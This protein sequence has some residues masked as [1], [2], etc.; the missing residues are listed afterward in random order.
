MLTQAS[1]SMSPTEVSECG[2]DDCETA[3]AGE[4][5]ECPVCLNKGLLRPLSGVCVAGSQ[6]MCSQFT[7]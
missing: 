2:V 1:L 5:V 6:R 4:T 3:D 7:F